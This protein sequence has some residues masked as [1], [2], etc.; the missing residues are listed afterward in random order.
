V[1]FANLS[2]QKKIKRK[3]KLKS[4]FQSVNIS[5][6][7]EAKSPKKRFKKGYL[8]SKCLVSLMILQAF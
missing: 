2:T 6:E 5:G 3:A 1:D 8:T 4:E 7:V